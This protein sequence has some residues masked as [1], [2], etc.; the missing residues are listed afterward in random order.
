MPE[1]TDP[2]EQ[3]L[4]QQGVLHQFLNQ[5]DDAHRLAGRLSVQLENAYRRIQQ[6]QV[7]VRE[8][9][10]LLAA[11]YPPGDPGGRVEK[12]TVADQY[13]AETDNHPPYV[14]VGD[15]Q[16]VGRVTGDSHG[17]V[18]E[19]VAEP[20]PNSATHEHLR[21]LWDTIREHRDRLDRLD[22]IDRNC[23]AMGY[24]RAR[25]RQEMHEHVRHEVAAEMKKHRAGGGGEMRELKAWVEQRYLLSDAVG[26]LVRNEVHAEIGEMA[27]QPP[28][29]RKRGQKRPV[30]GRPVRKRTKPRAS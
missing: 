27:N 4:A 28:R 10:A 29:P 3:L 24:N 20:A 25:D 30:E 23:F 15:L 26:P 14:S 12:T 22:G 11:A 6:L 7:E 5:R 9:D 1:P 16:A 2:A 17:E 18:N 21:V 19:E 8:R 13:A